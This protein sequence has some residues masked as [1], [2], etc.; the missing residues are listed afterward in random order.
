[1][2][3]RV[4][5]FLL[6]NELA[7]E[8]DNPRTKTRTSCSKNRNTGARGGIEATTSEVHFGGVRGSKGANWDY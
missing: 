6:L 5:L 2:T 7:C 3:L 4:L 1:M 8:G